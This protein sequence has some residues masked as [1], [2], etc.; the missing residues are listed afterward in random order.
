MTISDE[1]PIGDRRRG[2]HRAKL[3]THNKLDIADRIIRGCEPSADLA[4]EYRVTLSCIYKIVA[5]VRNKPGV[6]GELIN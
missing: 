2:K 5:Q 6:L 1:T 3:T 4:K